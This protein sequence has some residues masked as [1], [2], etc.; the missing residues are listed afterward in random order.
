MFG[1]PINARACVL[2]N[3]TVANHAAKLRHALHRDMR[4]LCE[5][6]SHQLLLRWIDVHCASYSSA[7]DSTIALYKVKGFKRHT[8]F[9]LQSGFPV[10][11]RGVES[12]TV[13]LVTIREM[14]CVWPMLQEIF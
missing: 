1:P 5:S 12:Q 6:P 10:V 2:P 11:V 14:P 8:C 7:D 13:P 4:G 3:A 9:L